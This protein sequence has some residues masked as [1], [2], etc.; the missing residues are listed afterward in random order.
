MLKV[1]KKVFSTFKLDFIP[2]PAMSIAVAYLPNGRAQASRVE[3]KEIN[4]L[5][6]STRTT[7]EPRQSEPTELFLIIIPEKSLLDNPFIRKIN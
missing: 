6:T 1:I 7:E 5:S 3:G 2:V 4:F